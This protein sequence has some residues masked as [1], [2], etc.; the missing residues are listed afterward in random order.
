MSPNDLRS[1][2]S[3]PRFI[4]GIYNYCDRWCE[5]CPLSDR[6][7]NY[8][9][10]KAEDNAD[11]ATRDLQNQ[12]FW[13]KLHDVFAQTIEMIRADARKLGIDL[14]NPDGVAAAAAEERVLRR[15]EAKNSRFARA[16]M[17]YVR[18]VD[19]WMERAR[20]LFAAKGLELETMAQLEIG[21]AQSEVARLGELVEV[22]RW[23]QHFIYVKLRR[24][25]SSLAE[26]E[27]ESDPEL[28]SFPKDS[29]GSAKIALIAIDRS[30]SAWA[31][32]RDQ[33]TDEAESIL[34]LLVQLGRLRRDA[35]NRFPQA[36]E[37]VR[38][39]FDTAGE[40]SEHEA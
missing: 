32:L 29:D 11:L 8:A 30:I 9:I 27:I 7:L 3:N 18:A 2:A 17:Q 28:R 6:C 34:D 4:A 10:E 35:E 16:A 13:D 36:R 40:P 23:Y 26:D 37:F 22:V 15:R 14:E 21:D 12:K 39:G 1:L 25:I 33:L 19:I 31:E 5:R 24:A 20:P 38:P